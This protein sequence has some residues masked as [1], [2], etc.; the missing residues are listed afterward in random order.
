M[1]T[2]NCP[3]CNRSIA[4][5]LDEMNNVFECAGCGGKFTPVGGAIEEPGEGAGASE[6][7]LRGEPFGDLR[8]ESDGMNHEREPWFYG[9]LHTWATVLLWLGLLVSLLLSIGLLYQVLKLL[10]IGE[11]G[12]ALLLFV[13]GIVAIG[14]SLLGTL[15]LYALIHL[16]LDTGRNVRDL[17]R[18]QNRRP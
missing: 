2:T 14:F 5:D 9:F 18:R 17:L 4:V 3:H 15:I 11:V 13:V 1:P 8:S 6:R 16:W 12:I 10:M 7:P